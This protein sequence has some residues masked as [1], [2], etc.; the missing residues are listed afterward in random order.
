MSRDEV[1]RSIALGCLFVPAC[2][3]PAPLGSLDTG[4]T[5]D[6][7]EGESDTEP[8]TDPSMS[9]TSA[10]TGSD[11]THS[12][13]DVG[14]A[15][16]GPPELDILFVMDNS[17]S[18]GP[19][20]AALAST[21][22]NLV[23]ALEV[24]PGVSY[25]VG[26]TTTDNGNPWC[27]STST[28]AGQ[29]VASSCRSRTGQFVFNGNPPADA[30]DI[31][32]TDIC[33]LDT[34]TFTPTPVAGEQGV[35]ARPWIEGG[36]GVTNLGGTGVGDALACMLPQGIAGCGFESPLE[37]AKKA[38]LRS[39][40]PGDNSFGFIRDS[41]HLVVVFVSDET[42][43]SYKGEH[44]WIF[45]DESSGGDP[46]RFWSDAS[47]ENGTPSSAVCWNAGVVC[48]GEVPGTNEYETCR[49]ANHSRTG[50]DVSDDEA[51]LEPISGYV[52]QFA[53]LLAAKRAT[54]EA[55]V[56]LYGVLGVPTGY[57]ANPLVF[58]PADDA[59]YQSDFGIGPG[60]QYD[61]V[62]ALPPVRQLAVIESFDYSNLAGTQVFSICD[63]NLGGVYEQIV[64]QLAPYLGG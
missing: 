54:S 52:D 60:C 63:P 3:I 21:I 11:T 49:A 43:C 38:I 6:A 1:A 41:A 18:M 19:H 35:R 2:V 56:F 25:R 53:D 27:G 24:V 29:L 47:I 32:C 28:E 51:V 17:G 40:L 13:P 62:K 10:D 33:T 7:T 4:S 45:L 57:P 39:Q 59:Q 14:P 16:A 9:G 37:S 34:L 48:E 46:S 64:G 5:G 44:Q 42:D 36:G 12:E 8:T 50:V 31:A 15:P 58:A 61:D 55:S 26:V 23:N 20:Q 22:D 30:T